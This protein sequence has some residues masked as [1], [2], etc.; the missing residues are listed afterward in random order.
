MLRGGRFSPVEVASLFRLG[1]IDPK[2]V[3]DWAGLQLGNGSPSAD[4]IELAGA[5]YTREI[6]V[7]ALLEKLIRAE[8]S[9]PVNDQRAAQVAARVVAREMLEGR[10]APIDGARTIWWRI[11]TVISTGAEMFDTFVGLASEWDDSPSFRTE[12]EADILRAARD[13]LASDEGST[14]PSAP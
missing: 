12:Y 2:R 6:E 1:L 8:G 5:K 13:L 11:A 3:I 14:P 4:M 9:L 10:I 7:A